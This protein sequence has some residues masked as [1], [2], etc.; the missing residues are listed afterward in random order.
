M[1]AI[2][3]RIFGAAVTATFGRAVS[4]QDAKQPNTLGFSN[5]RYWKILTEYQK[6]IFVIGLLQGLEWG[7]TLEVNEFRDDISSKRAEAAI[8]Q[9]IPKLTVPEITEAISQFYADPTNAPIPIGAMML[10]LKKKTAGETS[11]Q[12]DKR[13][14]DL[15]RSF[16]GAQ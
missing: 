12:I 15:R 8:D 1:L 16:G 10:V 2:T 4:G 6:P 3:R 9:A 5:G 7:T 13:L 14:A 11:T